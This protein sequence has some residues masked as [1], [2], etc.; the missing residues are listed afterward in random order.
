VRGK[1]EEETTLQMLDS[2][3]HRR[4]TGGGAERQRS[5]R[6]Q[7]LGLR[8]EEEDDLCGPE[9]GRVHWA[10]RS[11]GPILVGDRKNGGGPHEGTGRNQ[12]IKKNWLF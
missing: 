4:A 11:M 6:R 8:P 12:R 9:L 2:M 7:R 10:Q 5:S 3:A 1:E